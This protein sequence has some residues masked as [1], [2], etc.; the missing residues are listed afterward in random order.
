MTEVNKT[1]IQKGIEIISALRQRVHDPEKKFGSLKQPLGG[2]NLTDEF[3]ANKWW[4]WFVQFDPELSQSFPGSY[5]HPHEFLKQLDVESEY[6]DLMTEAILGKK[7]GI[8]KD[9]TLRVD[10]KGFALTVMN[11][12]ISRNALEMTSL[13]AGATMNNNRTAFDIEGF[14]NKPGIRAQYQRAMFDNIKEALQPTHRKAA[15]RIH[16][17]CLASGDS[18]MS[19][20]L[21]KII[22][23]TELEKMQKDGV[24]VVIDGP[25]TAQGI[26]FLKSFA[27]KFGFP[28]DFKVGHMAFGLSS[29]EKEGEMRKHANYITYPDEIMDLLE[30]GDR[31]GL[32]ES[33][34]Y[35]DGYK[36]VVQDMGEAEMGISEDEIKIVRAILDNANIAEFN[37]RRRDSHGEHPLHS[38]LSLPADKEGQPVAVYLARGGYLPYQ[39]DLDQGAIEGYNIEIIR[40]SRLWTKEYGYGTAFHMG[41]E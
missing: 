22:N 3:G 29:G 16:D 5:I 32:I 24:E 28:I 9:P 7:L 33:C 25:A 31:K 12:M 4:N 34:K 23:Q 13:A 41:E 30:N 14:K 6:F 18:I 38:T 37:E 39:F 36:Y 21:S 10:G 40:A 15:Y 35:P 8:L 19:Y 17:D 26:L 11:G 1:P 27:Q 20:L 2:I